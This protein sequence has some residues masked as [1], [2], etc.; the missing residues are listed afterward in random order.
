MHILACNIN[1]Y[2]ALQYAMI[3]ESSVFEWFAQFPLENSK[4]PNAK[5][6]L[7]VYRMT[8]NKKKSHSSYLH[9]RLGFS[10]RFFPFFCDT[11]GQ[12]AHLGPHRVWQLA[13]AKPRTHK[14]YK[15]L[16]C[17]SILIAILVINTNIFNL[18][19]CT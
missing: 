16:V 19:L 12:R 5:T 14:K 17:Y 10:F 1:L 7:I 4:R 18:N 13:R 8:K 9:L 11:G 6:Y 2:K 3:K 15:K